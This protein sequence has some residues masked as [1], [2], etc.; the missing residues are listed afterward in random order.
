MLDRINM[1][2]MIYRIM[3]ILQIAKNP[4]YMLDRI[5]MI[6]M[7]YKNHVNHGNPAILS[8]VERVT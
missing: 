3:L 6:P 8:N 7:I 5:N 4:V 2:P 1:I